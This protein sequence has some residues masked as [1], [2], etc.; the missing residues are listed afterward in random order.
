ML[1]QPTPED[2]VIATGEQ[3]SVRTFVTSAAKM[4][5]VNVD[6]RGK[7][8]EEH[9]I[10][11]ATGRTLVR[12]DPRYFRPTEVETLLGDASKA[13]TRLGWSPEIGFE[14]LVREMVDADLKL[15]ERDALI[16]REG[17]AVHSPRE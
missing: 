3:Y 8:L 12:V 11:K 2:Y 13:R 5:G 17:F 10:D 9:A 7:G 1:Q 15:A 6:W 16:A 4:L 14:A